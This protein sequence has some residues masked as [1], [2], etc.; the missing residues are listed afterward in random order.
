MFGTLE[1]INFRKERV[2]DYNQVNSLIESAFNESKYTNHQE[3]YLVDRLRKSTNFLPELSLV[4]EHK[5]E[6][7]GHILLTRIKIKNDSSEYESLALAPLSVLPKFQNIGIG[8]ELITNAH[9][10][11]KKLGFKSIIVIGLAEYYNRFGYKKASEFGI[12][13][14]FEAPDEN[15]MAIELIPGGLHQGKGIALY[16]PEFFY[17]I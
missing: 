7:I 2:E 17:D 5:S 8:S 12:K 1:K 11:A 6:I 15:F 16:P 10:E 14:P 3:Q 4:A 13:S 9:D